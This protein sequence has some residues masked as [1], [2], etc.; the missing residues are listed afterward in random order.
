MSLAAPAA[1]AAG[2]APDLTAGGPAGEPAYLAGLR[3]RGREVFAATGL[4]SRRQEAWRTTPLAAIAEL[5]FVPATALPFALPPEVMIAGAVRL[6]FVNGCF[7]PALSAVEQLAPG[8]TVVPL[9]AASP[10]TLVA[11]ERCA[12]AP[13][14]R[15]PFA[16]LNAAAGGDGAVVHLAAGAILERPIHLVFATLA[17]DGPTVA[18]PRVLVVADAGSRAVVVESHLGRGITLACPLSELVLAAGAVVEHVVVAEPGDGA[19]LV[20]SLGA[21]LA[22]GARLSCHSV[23]VDGALVRNDLDVV[24]LGE[25]AEAKLNGLCLASGRQYLENHLRVEHRAPRCASHQL[26]RGVVGGRARVAFTGR[27]VVAQDAQKT[28]ANQ[29][30]HNLLLSD[31]AVV[32]SNPQLEI[33][34]DDVRCTHGST[35]GRIDADALFYLR[36]RGIGRREAEGILTF[37]FASDLVERIP[38]PALAER[39]EALIV[40][41]L[42][43]AAEVVS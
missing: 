41:R 33:L 25:G 24:L 27:I 5:P 29:A 38:V 28:D 23:A 6:V 30:N 39:L 1:S 12:L 7:V 26:Y 22:A 42:A 36:S 21:T 14:E 18:Y 40:D 31:H 3:R 11:A 32:N 43:A 16:A 10:A 34:A 4:P 13:A 9:S 37:A 15:T 20:A 2:F 17:D 35:V 8:V 19:R